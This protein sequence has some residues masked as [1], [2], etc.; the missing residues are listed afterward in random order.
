MTQQCSAAKRRVSISANEINHKSTRLSNNYCEPGLCPSNKNH[1]GCANKGTFGHLCTADAR[2]VDLDGYNKRLI[3]HMHNQQRSE[4]AEGKTPGFPPAA[5]M[6]ALQW[7]DELAYLATL[8]AMS[9]EIE[10][11]KVSRRRSFT[12]VAPLTYLHF[13][14]PQHSCLP[15]CR[16]EPCHGLVAGRSHY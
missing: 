12:I 9:C 6:G 1:I 14:V 7:D 8:N 4:I 11:D 3:L 16:S 5:R 15:I 13:A 2:V 10:H